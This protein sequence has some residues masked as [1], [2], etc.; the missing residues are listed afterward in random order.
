M[1]LRKSQRGQAVVEIALVL[2]ILLLLIF[3]MIDIGRI[4]HTYMTVEHVSRESARAASVGDDNLEIAET[5]YQAAPALN[6]EYLSITISP[7]SNRSR[8]SYVSISTSYPVEILT[9]FIRQLLPNPFLVTS[10][11]VMRME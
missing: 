2:P 5:A 1:G 7:E 3:G 10:E 11:T 6:Q 4:I 8:G 9:P